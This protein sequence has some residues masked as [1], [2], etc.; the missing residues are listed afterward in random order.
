MFTVD[1]VM[2][3][4]EDLPVDGIWRDDAYIDEQSIDLPRTI[5]FAQV[6]E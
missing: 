3:H 4:I 1:E 6:R 5:R 2:L